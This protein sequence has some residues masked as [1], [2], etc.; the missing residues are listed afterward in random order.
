M[1]GRYATLTRTK[2]RTAAG[3]RMKAHTMVEIGLHGLVIFTAL[4]RSHQSTSRIASAP[5]L[6]GPTLSNDSCGGRG[7]GFRRSGLCFRTCTPVGLRAPPLGMDEKYTRRRPASRVWWCHVCRGIPHTQNQPISHDQGP[8][9][10][11]ARSPFIRGRAG[12]RTWPWAHHEAF[13]TRF[14][15]AGALSGWC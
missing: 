11:R 2:R 15:A 4:D 14:F 9:H 5:C 10:D 3:A 12:T 1:T 7:L 8:Q 13:I 6:E